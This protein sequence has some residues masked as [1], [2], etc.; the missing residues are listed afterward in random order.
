MGQ[1]S[2][3]F[4]AVILGSELAN[5]M[6]LLRAFTQ[7]A[8]LQDPGVWYSLPMLAPAILGVACQCLQY[9]EGTADKF[10]PPSSQKN[11]VYGSYHHS[12]WFGFL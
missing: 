4:R 9:P 11:G 10:R 6:V 2:A 7:G 1:L 12:V 8:T 3:R 5:G